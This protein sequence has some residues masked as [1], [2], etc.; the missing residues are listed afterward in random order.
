[1]KRDKIRDEARAEEAAAVAITAL[2]SAGIHENRVQDPDLMS[3]WHA[4]NAYLI[5]RDEDRVVRMIP[6]HFR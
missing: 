2:E 4:L 5:R 3:A 1:M 6:T